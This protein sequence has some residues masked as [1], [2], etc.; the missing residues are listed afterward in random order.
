MHFHHAAT[1]TLAS[2]ERPD[3]FLIGQVLA[4]QV[5]QLETVGKA[6]ASL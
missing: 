2:P 1:R 5:Q 4:Q 3:L 6:H